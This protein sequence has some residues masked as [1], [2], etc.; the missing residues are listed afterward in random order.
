M[1]IDSGLVGSTVGG[2]PREQKTLKGHLL[3]VTSQRV[4]ANIRRK[5]TCVPAEPL[6]S[7]A[8][9]PDSMARTCLRLQGSRFRVQGSGFRVQ[10]SGFRVQG[11]R[12]RVQSSGSGFRV[13]IGSGLRAEEARCLLT[14]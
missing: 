2:V 1:V 10:D 12:S 13:Q 6:M 5:F 4:Y 7:G 14:A 9:S 3:R 8:M 11:S